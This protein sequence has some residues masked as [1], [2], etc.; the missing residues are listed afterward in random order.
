MS[1]FHRWWIWFWYN[2]YT[3]MFVVLIPTYMLILVPVLLLILPQ[4]VITSWMPQ[5]TAYIYLIVFTWAML[6]NDYTN[7]NKIGL[8]VYR[9]PLHKPKIELVEIYPEDLVINLANGA[10]ITTTEQLATHSCTTTYNDHTY[11]VYLKE[12]Y[13]IYQ[14]NVTYE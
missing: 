14:R 10:L 9:N 2:D 12:K 7:L 5:I 3:R 4:S 13:P 8:D 1:K 6:D 11:T